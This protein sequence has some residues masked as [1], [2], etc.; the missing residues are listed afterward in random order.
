[1]GVTPSAQS[2]VPGTSPQFFS[3]ATKVATP[4]PSYLT[5]LASS[6]RPDGFAPFPCSHAHSLTPS[7]VY[8]AFTVC[9]LSAQSACFL[10]A[11][12][13]RSPRSAL[14]TFL[15]RNTQRKWC[16]VRSPEPANRSHFAQAHAAVTEVGEHRMMPT[17]G[18]D[19]HTEDNAGQPPYKGTLPDCVILNRGRPVCTAAR[20]RLQKPSAAPGGAGVGSADLHDHGV[21]GQR[22]LLS[23]LK[24]FDLSQYDSIPSDSDDE[25]PGLVNSTFRPEPPSQEVCYVNADDADRRIP[26][27]A[28][29]DA[30]VA[31]AVSGALREPGCDYAYIDAND[32]PITVGP[33]TRDLVRFASR[34]ADTGTDGAMGSQSADADQGGYGLYWG[35]AC[36]QTDGSEHEQPG[37]WGDSRS[38]GDVLPVLRQT[39]TPSGPNANTRRLA[40]VGQVKAWQKRSRVHKE[41]WHH[42]V[43]TKTGSCIFDPTRHNE[44]T[45]KEFVQIAD[46]AKE[47]SVSMV[48]SLH[49]DLSATKPAGNKDPAGASPPPARLLPVS[50]PSCSNLGGGPS[51]ARGIGHNE[52]E[53]GLPRHWTPGALPNEALERSSLNASSEP[54]PD[55]TDADQGTGRSVDTEHADYGLF[56]G[57]VCN[58]AGGAPPAGPMAHTPSDAPPL[59][60]VGQVRA[61]LERSDAHEE[62]WRHFVHA[63]TESTLYNPDRHDEM[64]LK[65]FTVRTANT[66]ALL[67]M[68]LGTSSLDASLKMLPDGT[69]GRGPPMRGPLVRFK[70]APPH[71]YKTGYVI[72]TNEDARWCLV[73][74]LDQ[75]SDVWTPRHALR[76]YVLRAGDDLF[77]EAASYLLGHL[78]MERNSPPSLT[79]CT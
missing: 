37:A 43:R 40:L 13:I 63:K 75:T 48:Q 54:L 67:A 3:L 9:Q 25:E 77:D 71:P 57:D 70:E 11:L 6:W 7:P 29:T 36:G 64:T 20:A 65:D 61:W 39:R 74:P 5:D 26:G 59:T 33:K 68:A 79:L 56:W 72:D 49:S 18:A 24:R 32:L 38:A 76:P 22:S 30:H 16:S 62:I 46:E 17:R 50:A 19:G 60:L 41:T 28:S 58:E 73:R 21:R 78:G 47:A 42:F 52:D 15:G 8:P 4:D 14:A 27:R 69:V 35:S 2:L 12:V 1:M 53:D 23:A 45:L 51:D 34:A 44:A 31:M 55:G 66:D 10:R